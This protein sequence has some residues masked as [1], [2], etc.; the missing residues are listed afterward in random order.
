MTV[1]GQDTM[2]VRL[3]QSSDHLWYKLYNKLKPREEPVFI[4]AGTTFTT[5][6]WQL[7]EP[8]SSWA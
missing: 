7:L 6:L 1:G 5:T 3:R 8:R 2:A 4:P